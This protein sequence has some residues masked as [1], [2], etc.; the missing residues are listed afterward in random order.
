MP[1]Q[2]AW[3]HLVLTKIPTI[4]E[5]LPVRIPA[6]SLY[7]EQSASPCFDWP[8]SASYHVIWRPKEDRQ[9]LSTSTLTSCSITAGHGGFPPLMHGSILAL[10]RLRRRYKWT[11]SGRMVSQQRLPNA[12][13]HQTL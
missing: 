1:R 2:M 4:G 6:R 3:A 10:R 12:D 13:R 9:H 5:T 11:T 7:N 8:C